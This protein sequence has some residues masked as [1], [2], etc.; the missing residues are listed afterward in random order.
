[1]VYYDDLVASVRSGRDWVSNLSNLGVI[2]KASEDIEKLL[3]ST[4]NHIG[5][6]GGT[7]PSPLGGCSNSSKH[8]GRAGPFSIL[9]D[10]IGHALD[11]A[12]CVEAIA[13]DLS[14][15]IQQLIKQ[16]PGLEMVKLIEEQLNALK[17]VSEEQEDGHSSTADSASSA[18]ESTIS[19]IPSPSL[20]SSTAS[21]SSTTVESCSATYTGQADDDDY[22][23]PEDRR[24]LVK[25]RRHSAP[26]LMRRKDEE[27]IEAIGV[28][29]FPEQVSAKPP[30]FSP[31]RKF[32]SFGKFPQQN[33]REDGRIYD[34]ASKWYVVVR[35][36]KYF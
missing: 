19:T 18:P 1:M 29:N 31:L 10:L 27:L 4:E 25:H 28:C 5:F 23:G 17:Q 20:P 14:A 7:F 33:N 21:S 3:R 32:L 2:G 11:L 26:D 15:E 6:L 36:G 13:E 24:S 9:K 16:P 35:A 30:P 8:K 34:A 22:D 12:S